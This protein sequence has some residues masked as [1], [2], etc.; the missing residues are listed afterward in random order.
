MP[1]LKRYR[2]Q[3]CDDGRERDWSL[4][5]RRLQWWP[6][7]AMVVPSLERDQE[8]VLVSI[9][10]AEME[11]TESTSRTCILNDQLVDPNPSLSVTVCL[12]WAQALIF[13]FNENEFLWISI[14]LQILIMYFE[15]IE[16]CWPQLQCHLIPLKIQSNFI[17]F[18]QSILAYG[19]C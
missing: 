19:L 14:P 12:W 6:T 8:A 5:T 9:L 18:T 3:F 17:N 1:L 4:F 11:P 15:S 7:E 10:W 2:S 16:T 13:V